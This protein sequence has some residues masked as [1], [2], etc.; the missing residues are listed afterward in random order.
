M[1]AVAAVINAFEGAPL[2]DALRRAAVSFLV[3]GARRG[4]QGSAAEI[5]AEFAREMARRPIA[6]HT[7]AA[8]DQHYELPAAFFE[9]VLGP[10][11][12]YSSCLYPRGDE[13]LAQAEI[14]ALSATCAHADLEDG[15]DI[16]ELGCGWGSLSLWMAAHYPNARITSVSNSASQRAF[17]EGRAAALGLS[18]LTIVT[19]DMNDFAPSQRF[20]R[21]VSVEMFEHMANW[22]ELLTRV[23][24]WLK[25]EGALFIHVFSHRT[26][27]YRFDVNDPADWIAQH[28]FTGGVMPSHGLI[29]QFDDLFAVEADWVWNGSHYAKTAED[30]LANFD[31]HAEEIG[32]VMR[33]VYGKD[34]KLWTRRWRLFFLSTAG[35]FGHA[36][37]EE[38]GVS[39]Y[40]LRP[41]AKA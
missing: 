16:L 30:W 28:F 7:K 39:H 12:K 2:P 27:P 29:R 1:S 8:N 36:G 25:P 37:G 20:D 5:D 41:A 3:E 18:N 9:R 34:A 6:E 40:R 23:H 26:T 38:W 22:R 11:L 35:L 32:Q 14:A 4:L 10:R 33:E 13:T 19:A 24:G 21:V 31:R 15:Q 17:I